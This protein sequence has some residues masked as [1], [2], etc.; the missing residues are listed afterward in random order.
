[1]QH[2]GS[3]TLDAHPHSPRRPGTASV[4]L[5]LAA[6]VALVMLI[7]THTFATYLA[8]G[9]SPSAALAL[10]PWHARALVELADA[11]LGPLIAAHSAAQTVDER[12]RQKMLMERDENV[13]ARLSQLAA[14]GLAAT[15][16]PADETELIDNTDRAPASA[17][18]T[19]PLR[20]DAASVVAAY[21]TRAIAA[22]PLNADAVGI[23]ARLADLDGDEARTAQLMDLTQRLSMRE[24]YAVYWLMQRS[25]ASGDISTAL[26]YANVLLSSRSATMPYVMPTIAQLA[27]ADAHRDHVVALFATGPIWRSTAFSRLN[28]SIRDARTPLKVM[29]GLKGSA[30]P[31]T[32]EEVTGYVRFLVNRNFPEIAYSTWLQFQPEGFISK[33][34]P[35]QNG[36]FEERLTDIPFDWNIRKGTNA[37]VAIRPRPGAESAKALQIDFRSSRGTFPQ[38]NQHILLGPGQHTLR[39]IYQGSLI[40]PRGLVWRVACL[41]GPVLAMTDNIRGKHPDWRPFSLTFTVPPTGCRSQQVTLDLDARAPSEMMATG[42]IFFDDLEIVRGG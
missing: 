10:N 22:D 11:D 2:R 28:T 41:K 29:L 21:A 37:S 16:Q 39:G 9:P 25:V 17:A 18:A 20:P 4:I 42:T 36:S 35:L 38:V 19:A 7:V 24:S 5:S 26:R 8:S 3:D 33:L 27:E 40:S 12:T 6:G 34:R 31:P 15:E 14:S 32:P 23:L 13:L 30:H 1:M